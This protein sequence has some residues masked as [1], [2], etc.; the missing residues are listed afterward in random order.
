MILTAFILALAQAASEGSHKLEIR[1]ERQEGGQW[2]AADPGR[3]LDRDDR[4]RFGLR[5]NFD[6]YLYVMNKTTS[7]RF[8][9]LFPSD[10]A[11]QDNRIAAGRQ[12]LVPATDGSF[13]ITGP[14]GH[15]V[16]YWLVSPVE[17]DKGYTPLP[18]P[19]KPGRTPASLVPRCDDAILR[20]RGECIDR[21]AGL[22]PLSETGSAP[23]SLAAMQNAGSRDLV[24]TRQ[25]SASV[26]AVPARLEGP[27]IFEFRLAHR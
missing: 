20:A 21:S 15:E 10:Q 12:Y 4:V 6:G 7:G 22:K 19:P 23:E 8:T 27:V 25:E 16:V 11:G 1:L 13:R 2:K 24:F 18:H 5:A 3:I 26:V 14:P 17:L 9:L